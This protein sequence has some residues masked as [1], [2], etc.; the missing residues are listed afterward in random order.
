MLFHNILMLLIVVFDRNKYLQYY[1]MFVLY[2]KKILLVQLHVFVNQLLD[3]NKQEL[4]DIHHVN[5]KHDQDENKFS[6]YFHDLVIKS[7]KDVLN[8]F[9]IFHIHPYHTSY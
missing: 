1:V 2:Q 6:K 3:H 9:L 5:N 7:L 8:I 4:V